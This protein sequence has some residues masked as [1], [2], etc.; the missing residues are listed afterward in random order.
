M[1]DEKVKDKVS[2]EDKKTVEEACT[3]TTQ[4]LEAN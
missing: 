2:D 4:W 3:E 1:M